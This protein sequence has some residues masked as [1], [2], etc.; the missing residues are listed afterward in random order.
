MLDHCDSFTQ[1]VSRRAV[2]FEIKVHYI[3]LVF[4][5]LY[6]WDTRGDFYILGDFISAFSGHAIK[7]VL[8][9]YLPYPS[10]SYPTRVIKPL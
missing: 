10:F 4:L 3:K 5:A 7:V 8:Q 9:L 6:S 2:T 1:H